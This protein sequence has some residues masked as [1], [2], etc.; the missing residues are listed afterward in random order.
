MVL[1]H[2]SGVGLLPDE[3]SFFAFPPGLRP[4][5]I[6]LYTTIS[7][8]LFLLAIVEFFS[9]VKFFL[10]LGHDFLAT[11]QL[12]FQLLNLSIFE[13]LLIFETILDFVESSLGEVMG[14]DEALQ[15]FVQDIG[16]VLNH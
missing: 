7:I 14:F 13:V 1:I 9:L 15:G 8:F 5:H 3:G 11:F 6:S 16:V 4:V 12:G 10:H 2:L